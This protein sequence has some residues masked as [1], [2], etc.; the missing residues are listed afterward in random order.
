MGAR[1]CIDVLRLSLSGEVM[2]T[3]SRSVGQ[4][5]VLRPYKR[6]SEALLPGS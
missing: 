2:M 1:V 5:P 4:G 6:N 3:A